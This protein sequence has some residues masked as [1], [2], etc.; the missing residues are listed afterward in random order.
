MPLLETD[1]AL[2]QLLTQSHTIAVVGLSP[3][4][5][6]DSNRV[7]RFLKDHGYTILPVNPK[8]SSV[9]GFS[10]YPN[11]ESIQG[12]VDIVNIFRRSEYVP[13]IV[14]SAIRIKAKAV[15]MQLGV[16]D[17]SAAETASAAGL[18]VVMDRCILIEHHR[19]MP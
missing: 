19:L 2:L 18:Q 6:R 17:E 3:D 14:A 13:P 12:T 10:S 7:A 5:T 1:D 9:F 11:L 16:I 8:I 15:W 4:P